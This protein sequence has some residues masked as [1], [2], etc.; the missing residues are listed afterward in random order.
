MPL[1]RPPGRISE[2]SG[3]QVAFD[4]K[5][6]LWENLV[7]RYARTH[8]QRLDGLFVSDVMTRDVAA[9]PSS[10][11]MDEAASKLTAFGVSGAPVVDFDGRCIGV[12]SAA[13]F[14]RAQCCDEEWP[15]IGTSL[16]AGD[17]RDRHWNSVLRYM[18]SPV[19]TISPA[20]P[21]TQAAELMCLAHVHRLIV[22]DDHE[23]PVGLV[24]TFD[25]VQ[26]LIYA[27]DEQRH[28]SDRP[29]RG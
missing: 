1:G 2:M 17:G 14:L 28:G 15:Q 19:H 4:S 11:T 12:L 9:I 25:V 16:E 8:V 7:F 6:K 5:Q 13:D 21:M 10:A 24:S 23:R 20:A 22:L 26:A 3:W 18:S 27:C 29:P